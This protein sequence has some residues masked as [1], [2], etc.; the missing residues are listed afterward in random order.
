MTNAF[1]KLLGAVLLA[2]LLPAAP[3]GAVE[4]DP[5]VVI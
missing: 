2:A 3:A 5:K 1:T 4:L